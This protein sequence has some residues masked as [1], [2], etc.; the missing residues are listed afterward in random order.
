MTTIGKILA[1][2]QEKGSVP[3]SRLEIETL[4]IVPLDMRAEYWMSCNPNVLTSTAR[5]P[6]VLE[7]SRDMFS[8]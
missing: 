7:S 2:Y 3:N 4:S 6:G 8:D 5:Y 1:E